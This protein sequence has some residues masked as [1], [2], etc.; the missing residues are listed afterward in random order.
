MAMVGNC[1]KDPLTPQVCGTPIGP[2]HSLVVIAM[3]HTHRHKRLFSSHGNGR[4]LY[5]GPT[6]TASVWNSNKTF[7]SHR[8]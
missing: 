6:H 4:E 1:I 5:Q 2:G 3:A 8:N 7:S